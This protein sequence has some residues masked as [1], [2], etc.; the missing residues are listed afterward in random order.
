MW[1]VG[2]E[3][4]R[5]IDLHADIPADIVKRRAIGEHQ[6][7]ERYHLH[8]LRQGFVAALIVPIWVESPYKPAAALK[9]GLQIADSLLEDLEESH[10]FRLVKTHNELLDAEAEGKIGLILGA[11]GGEFIEDDLG[12]LRTFYR[13]GLRCFGFCWNQRNLMAD[14]WSHFKDDRGLTDFGR[15]IV[16]EVNR[17]G[18]LIDLA[19][20]SRKGFWGVLDATR[21]PLIVSHTCTL[22]D[23]S[24][25]A[26]RD[27][28][29]KAVASNGGIIGIIAV[30]GVG[31]RTVYPTIP[32]L[33][34]YCDHIEYAVKVAGPEH[35][36]LG[37]DFYDYFIEDLVTEYP[38]MKYELVEG[39]EDHSKLGAVISELSK[40]GLT[41][42]EIR[43]IARDNF[44]R[45]FKEVVG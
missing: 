9:R 15:Q 13:L 14:G 33:K 26:M 17:L 12:L 42:D 21:K 35:V 34:T 20:M 31:D 18:V 8:K 36:G 30:R 32:D 37:P 38:D 41:D 1:L 44:V 10:S 29:L 39:L 43:M 19:H 23:P 27:E 6:V 3:L 45:V 24:F 40:R 5:I 11:E 25:R 16:D 7:L 2:R 28:Q 4:H 22:L